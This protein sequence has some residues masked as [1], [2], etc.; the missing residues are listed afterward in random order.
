MVALLKHKS[1]YL[2]ERERKAN[3][4]TG[5]LRHLAAGYDFPKE[6]TWKPSP[7]VGNGDDRDA[8][9]GRRSDRNAW[10]YVEEEG[11]RNGY[12]SG[13]NLRSEVCI[14]SRQMSLANETAPL[15]RSLFLPSFL[16]NVRTSPPRWLQ[17]SR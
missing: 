9:L 10:R 16:L 3:W 13:F 6:E 5:F 15:E 11:A 8:K 12:L 17:I 4:S 1:T 2:K 14:Y 7:L